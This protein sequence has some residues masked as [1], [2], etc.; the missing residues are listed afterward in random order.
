MQTYLPLR[1][2]WISQTQQLGKLATHGQ[3]IPS[4]PKTESIGLLI[5]MGAAEEW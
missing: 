5:S 3:K 1:P 4:D 2:V